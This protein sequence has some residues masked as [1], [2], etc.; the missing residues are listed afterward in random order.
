MTVK[1]GDFVEIEYTGKLKDSGE[2]FDTTNK[3]EAKKA[4]IFAEKAEY[5]PIIIC[6]G[7][8]H[9]L[10]G[11][12]SFI[13]GKDLGKHTVDLT[14]EQAFGK[15]NPELVKIL[16]ISKFKEQNIKP[17]PGLRLNIDGHVATVKSAS[18]GRIILDFNHP[19][20][21]KELVYDIK[22]NRI[23]EDKKEQIDSLFRTLLSINID[24]KI[25]GN[26]AIVE[27]PGK[28]PEQISKQ[29]GKKISELAKIEVEITAKE[30]KS[31]KKIDLTKKSKE[32]ANKEN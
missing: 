23:I 12:D 8:Q 4:N 19:L 2:V 24:T 26:K 1:K 15:K 17:V 13:E 7:E 5:K 22:L 3:E 21:G 6:V 32:N 25:T 18:G 31:E 29:L 11:I 10:P 16:P 9:I 27:L 30:N 20:A 28:I 14:P